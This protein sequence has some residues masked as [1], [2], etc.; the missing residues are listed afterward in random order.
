MV[1][2]DTGSI[3][4]HVLSPVE[5]EVDTEFVRVTI[6][7]QQMAE[8]H[9]PERCIKPTRI[10]MHSTVLVGPVSK[11]IDEYWKC[12]KDYIICC[13]TVNNSSL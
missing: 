12:A 7:F 3:G 6:L 8:N 5:V 4:Q 11:T 1:I 13:K 10:V 9:V 2:G